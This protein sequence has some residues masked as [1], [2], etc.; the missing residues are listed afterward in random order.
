MEG[1]HVGVSSYEAILGI[2]VE[3]IP[4]GGMEELLT[5]TSV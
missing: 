1:E 5:S 2:T 4:S 3:Q